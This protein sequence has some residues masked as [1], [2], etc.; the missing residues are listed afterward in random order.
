MN[1]KKLKSASLMRRKRFLALCN[2]NFE[3]VK[4][5]FTQEE[6]DWISAIIREI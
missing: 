1:N 4:K 5:H 6:I 3:W 2:R